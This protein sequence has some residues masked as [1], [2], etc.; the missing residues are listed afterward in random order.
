VQDR[1]FE[2]GTYI[3]VK[4][5]ERDTFFKISTF[6]YIVSDYVDRIF[7]AY[8]T[9][10]GFYETR[11]KFDGLMLRYN[12]A[13]GEKAE[14]FVKNDFDVVYAVGGRATNDIAVQETEILRQGVYN[15]THF[16][17]MYVRD[18]HKHIIEEDKKA[19]KAHNSQ[20]KNLKQWRL[21]SER[22]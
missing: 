2:R 18:L 5:I 3:S 8:N 16:K 12:F 20:L 19:S 7:S 14:F 21:D 15:L 22:E 9:H 6:K 1:R 17:S 10:A 4:P 11:E 13:N